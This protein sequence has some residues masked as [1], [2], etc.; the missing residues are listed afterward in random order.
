M[1]NIKYLPY[2]RTASN[3]E[4]LEFSEVKGWEYECKL[5]IASTDSSRYSDNSALVEGTHWPVRKVMGKC[6]GRQELGDENHVAP[7]RATKG[8]SLGTDRRVKVGTHWWQT[9]EYSQ[10]LWCHFRVLVSVQR[11][12]WKWKAMSKI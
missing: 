1:L 3:D 4:K 12:T 5:R 6:S 11:D 8:K 10:E 2:P 7:L 9:Q